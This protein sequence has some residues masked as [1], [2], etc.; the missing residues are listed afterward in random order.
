MDRLRRVVFQRSLQKRSC[1]HLDRV[2]VIEPSSPDCPVCL[3]EGER[4]VHVRMCMTCGVPGCCDS[5]KLQ[6]ARKHHQETGHPLIRSVEPGESWGWCYL[7]KA[8]L[9]QKD[10]LAGGA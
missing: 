8:Y 7:D 5:S 4:W 2:E 6:H 1:Q 9:T 3:D 10:Y